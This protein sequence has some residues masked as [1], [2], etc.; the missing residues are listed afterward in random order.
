[1]LH[2]ECSNF[3]KFRNGKIRETINFLNLTKTYLSNALTMRF[4]NALL[5][6]VRVK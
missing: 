4:V 1:M 6:I 3:S 5:R 2:T